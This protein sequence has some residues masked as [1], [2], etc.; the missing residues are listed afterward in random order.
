MS[1][2]RPLSDRLIYSARPSIWVDEERSDR[3]DRLLLAM[4][5]TESEAGLSAL[6]LR[7]SNLA[8]H[9]NGG[10]SLAFEGA[11]TVLK[12]G[13]ALKV[14]AGDQQSPVEI[15]RG[16]I[17][18]VEAEFSQDAPPELIIL[19]EDALQRARMQRRTVV[20]DNTTIKQVAEAVANA[21]GLTPRVDG[22]SDDIGQQV[23][24]NES[25]LA[26]LR[27]LL[28]SYDGDVQV[29]GDDLVVTPRRS[30]HRGDVTLA[31]NSQLT[32]VRVVADLA[33]QVTSVSLSG[34]DPEQADPIRVVS[35]G[36]GALGPGQGSTG[37]S[38][39]GSYL[40]G[41]SSGRSEHL[42]H[43]GSLKASEARAL[44][45]AAYHQRARRFVLAEGT[46]DG[47]PAIR[48][49]THLT[50]RGLSGRFDNAYYVTKA[51]HRFDLQAGYTT[52]FE[53]ECAYLGDAS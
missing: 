19:A 46:A 34:W 9:D 6:E 50:L 49:G 11:D 25:D 1:D 22:F 29:V 27:R 20:H 31:L 33:H 5:M 40:S 4:K 53:A 3:A 52:D 39:L 10:A 42:G 30:S 51:C 7:Y 18:C 32:R 38:A 36:S 21:A 12:L 37:A 45:D 16:V 17:T 41:G 15:F 44:A 35:Q 14:G 23:Q 24:L 48:V 28:R 8:S 47:N 13:A 43:F 26:F 2:E